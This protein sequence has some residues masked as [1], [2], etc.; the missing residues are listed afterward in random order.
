MKVQRCFAAEYTVSMAWVAW[1]SLSHPGFK[2][3]SYHLLKKAILSFKSWQI[4]EC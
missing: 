3:P 4:D 2:P 1:I